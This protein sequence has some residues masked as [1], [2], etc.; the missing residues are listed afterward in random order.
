MQYMNSY[1]YMYQ[2]QAKPTLTNMRKWDDGIKSKSTCKMH[3]SIIINPI[4]MTFYI[5]VYDTYII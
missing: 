2:G 4:I 1:S 5:S 3:V